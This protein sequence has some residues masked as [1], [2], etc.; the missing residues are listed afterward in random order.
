MSSEVQ[1]TLTAFDQA[2]E[3]INNVGNAVQQMNT[4]VTDSTQQTS[5]TI[6]AA[7]VTTKDAALSFNNMAT[8]GMNLY[9]AVNNIENAQVALDRAHLTVE[10]STNEVTS[11]QNA[12]N[13]AVEKYG[14]NS[15]EAQDALAKL[16]T[17]QDGLVV[18]QERADEAQRNY[19]NTLAF[20]AMS[21]IPS[22]VTMVT[23]LMKV[24]DFLADACAVD[25]AAEDAEAASETAC[26]GATGILAGA[27][28]ALS[29]AMT[30]LAMN[31]LVIAITAIV[32]LVAGLIYAY[33]NC[34]PFR[35]AIN[36][37]G[38]VLEHVFAGAVRSITEALT[39]LWNNVLAPL[40]AFLNSVFVACI[41]A[42][43]TVVGW[44]WTDCFKPL[45]E[46]L[47]W[48][49]NNIL[50][51]LADFIEKTFG[52]A[53][54]AVGT[55]VSDISGAIGGLGSALSHLSFVHAAPAAEAFNKTLHDS[56]ALTDTLTGKVS[57]LSSSLMSVSGAAGGGF[58]GPSAVSGIAAAVKPVAPTINIQKLVNIEGSADEKTAQR[59]AQM[60][61]A[62]LREV[63]IEPTSMAT[64]NLKRV[65]LGY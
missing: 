11:A 25:E 38:A 49:W 50:K 54:K 52:G 37:I 63:I 31:P 16:K 20:S 7:N 26:A 58:G 62:K 12:Y 21:V 23:S 33:Q 47:V 59:A 57:G 8:S 61:Q 13:T 9:M 29:G 39:W 4:D 44:L 45:Q 14:P 36:E 28:E 43:G 24:K 65:R 2:T 3:T 6:Q 56:I 48:L 35:D 53:I 5:T 15:K 42:L 32:A 1:I 40:G 41:Q 27:T 60:V 64:P 55:I 10:K 30:F 46:G 34:A 17:A 51:P 19:N 18:A 22:V